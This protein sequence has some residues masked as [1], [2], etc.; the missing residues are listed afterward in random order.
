VSAVSIKAKVGHIYLSFITEQS[1][2]RMTALPTL[3][4]SVDGFS[5]CLDWLPDHV[6]VARTVTVLG[7]TVPGEQRGLFLRTTRLLLM[8]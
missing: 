1:T 3:N 6:P 4:A 5:R 7:G 2:A 8:I